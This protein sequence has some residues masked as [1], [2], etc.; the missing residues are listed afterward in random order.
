MKFI[1]PGLLLLLSSCMELALLQEIAD[2]NNPGIHKEKALKQVKNHVLFSMTQCRDEFKSNNRTLGMFLFL[3]AK[4]CLPESNDPDRPVFNFN[5]YDNEFI[6]K[7]DLN[8]CLNVVDLLNC[9]IFEK[10]Q[11]VTLNSATYI[12]S[13]SFKIRNPVYIFFWLF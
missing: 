9:S 2:A 11:Y 5:C 13:E 6:K 12:C 4:K 1:I 8:K 7:K 10:N 3:G